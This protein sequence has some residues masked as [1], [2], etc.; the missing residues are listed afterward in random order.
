MKNAIRYAQRMALLL[1]ALFVTSHASASH[2]MGGNL[3]Y[4]YLGINGASGLYEYRVTLYVYRLCDPGSSALPNTMNFGAY[5]DN[6][7]NPSGSKQ[8][9][10][11]ISL[12]LLSQQFIQPPNANDSCTFLPSVCVEEGIYQN[13]V[14]LPSNT[15]GF[16]FIADRCCRNNNIANLDNPGG[17]GQAYYA[18]VPPPNI[19]NS[20]PERFFI[21]FFFF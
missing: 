9:L 17:T 2:L 1:V 21:F 20:A 10:S 7:G 12:P 6:P 4:E 11:S 14:S 15:T 13:V 19:V 8:L 18:Q 5:Q 3:T 16:Y